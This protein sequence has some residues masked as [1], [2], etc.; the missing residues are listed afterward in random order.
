MASRAVH[1]S[2]AFELDISACISDTSWVNCSN[3]LLFALDFSTIDKYTSVNAVTDTLR[4]HA[5]AR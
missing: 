1:V 3:P 5:A 4:M 2:N